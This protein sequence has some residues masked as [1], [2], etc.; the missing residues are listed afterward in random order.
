ME[1]LDEEA[2][3]GDGEVEVSTLPRGGRERPRRRREELKGPEEFRF[4]YSEFPH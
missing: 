4:M 3:A 1:R 2:P